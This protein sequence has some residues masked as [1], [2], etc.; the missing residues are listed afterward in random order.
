MAFAR[1]GNL[2]IYVPLRSGGLAQRSTG[3]SSKQVVR[4][5]ERLVQGLKDDRRWKLLEPVTSKPQRLSLVQLYDANAA[6]ALDQLEESLSS[7]RLA[8]VRGAWLASVQA[9]LGGSVDE[10]SS[11]QNYATQVDTFLAMFPTATA[12]DIV[13]A[14]VSSWL[15]S[16]VNTTPG[17]RRK[18]LYAM[19]SLVAYL[20]ETGALS[21]D[22]LSGYKA[23][24]KNK[25]RERW[26]PES[27]DRRIVEAAIP[28]Y[29]AFFAFIKA[30]GCDV[31]TARRTLVRDLDLARK[32][33]SQRDQD[34][35]SAGPRGGHRTVGPSPDPRADQGEAA[36]GLPVSGNHQLRREPPPRTLLRR[37][38]G[39]R[40]HPQGCAP[41]GGRQD[42]E[43]RRQLRGDCRSAR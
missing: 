4:A 38:G 5:I 43:T 12:S 16:R 39:R 30:T 29:R 18:Y 37:S 34:S 15:A 13:P 31:G 21:R 22:P 9:R 10:R 26:V 32:G 35:K 23:P 8:E 42:A 1:G 14:N 2:S 27:D 7:I 25:A 33:V 24:K 11:V 6:N 19:K 17:T 36:K 41:L 28:Q 20:V 40:L 3:T